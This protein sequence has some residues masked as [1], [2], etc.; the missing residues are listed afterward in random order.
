MRIGRDVQVS[1]T[2]DAGAKRPKHA[3]GHG[4]NDTQRRTRTGTKHADGQGPYDGQRRTRTGTKSE[5]TEETDVASRQ[6]GYLC[7]K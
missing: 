1:E 3:D 4:L 6:N 5:K 7:K 2:G